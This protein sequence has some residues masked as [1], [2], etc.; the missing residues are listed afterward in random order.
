MARRNQL[1]RI[2]YASRTRLGPEPKATHF[3]E[4][5]CFVEN[6]STRNRLSFVELVSSLDHIL[7]GSPERVVNGLIGKSISNRQAF[8]ID[9]D[10]RV[11]PPSVIGELALGGDVVARGYNYPE[12]MQRD[13]V[14]I[15]VAGQQHRVYKTGDRARWSPLN[16]N[17]EF[18]GRLY[19]QV[20]LRGQKIEVGERICV[21]IESTPILKITQGR[22]SRKHS[23]VNNLVVTL[24]TGPQGDKRLIAFLILNPTAIP[25]IFF[26]NMLPTSCLHM[27][28]LLP[29]RR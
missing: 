4:R 29:S 27:W 28:F 20:K 13:F 16:G 17:I 10:S 8:I 1:P 22:S 18:L 15:V 3:R 2:D 19:D 11:V 26:G 5:G 9:S 23:G 14:N 12:L 21:I 25:P 7:R 24:H 6:P